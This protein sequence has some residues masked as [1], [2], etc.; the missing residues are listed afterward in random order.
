ME[1]SNSDANKSHLEA[2]YDRLGPMQKRVIGIILSIFAGVM[3][4]VSY[5]PVTYIQDNYAD[6]SRNLNDYAFSFNAGI[7]ITSLVYFVIYC[8][9]ERN[10]PK[11]YPQ[12]ILPSLVTGICIHLACSTRLG[13]LICELGIM[14]MFFLSRKKAG[15]GA[16]LTRATSTPRTLSRK[17]SPFRCRTAVRWPSPFL[18]RFSTKRYAAPRISSSYS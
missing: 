18:S 12:A 1:Q 4:G 9:F 8:A 11:L 17:R 6:A 2:F 7:F 3:F 16:S 10:E 14:T 13:I 15:S 5:T